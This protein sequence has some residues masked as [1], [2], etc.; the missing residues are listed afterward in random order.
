[1]RNAHLRRS[2]WQPVL[3]PAL[4]YGVSTLAKEWSGT[5]SLSRPL[6]TRLII[7]VVRALA[8]HGL[9]RAGYATDPMYAAKLTR[10]IQHSLA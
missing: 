8:Q 10:I 1:M 2:G 4:P 6:V 5:V 7:E 9:Q 3:A